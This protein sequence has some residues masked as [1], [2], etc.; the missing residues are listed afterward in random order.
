MGA[1]Q[2]VFGS[3]GGGE[4]LTTAEKAL[5][6]NLEAMIDRSG[7]TPV[8]TEQAFTNVASTISTTELSG[9]GTQL[10]VAANATPIYVDRRLE[11]GLDIYRKLSIA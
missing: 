4:P 11:N 2:S 8:F 5:L 7:S 6:A 1:F 9:I 10:W 3:S